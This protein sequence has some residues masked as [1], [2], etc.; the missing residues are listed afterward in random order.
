MRVYCLYKNNLFAFQCCPGWV[1]TD[2]AGD[3]APLTPEQGFSLVIFYF[4]SIVVSRIYAGAETPVFLAFLPPGSPTGLFFK[5]KK[6]V[7]W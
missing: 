6:V 4:I 5:Q 3:R 7:D 1:K 2:M